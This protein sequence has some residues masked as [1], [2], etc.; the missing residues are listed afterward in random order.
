MR[1]QQFVAMELL[2]GWA[3][4]PEGRKREAQQVR[5]INAAVFAMPMPMPITLD[6]VVVANLWCKSIAEKP[7]SRQT[8]CL[9]L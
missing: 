7:F 2:K 4:R 8:N 3:S 6:V 5:P 9:L 1:P